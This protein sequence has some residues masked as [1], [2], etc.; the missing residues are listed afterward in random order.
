MTVGVARAGRARSG[1][2]A[3]AELQVSRPAAKLTR[4]RLGYHPRTAAVAQPCAVRP[5]YRSRP[6]IFIWGLLEARLK[7][8]DL[9]VLGGLNE[10]V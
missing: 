6:R 10:N 3:S 9:V 1:R 5:P 8:A 4:L 7:R 2:I